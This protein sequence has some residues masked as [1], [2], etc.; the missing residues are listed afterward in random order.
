VKIY[1]GIAVASILG[2]AFLVYYN[3]QKTKRLNRIIGKQKTELEELGHVKDRIFS[4]VSHDM[5]TPV[6]TLISFIDIL[7]DDAIPQ[8]K[9]QLYAGELKNQLSHTSVLM[10]NLLNWASS[11]MEGFTPLIEP[12]AVKD[13]VDQTMALLQQQ[14]G[15]KNI[16]I[17]NHINE[18][19]RVRG[20]RNMFALITR[21][22]L[23][24]AIKFTPLNGSVQVNT[25][26]KDGMVNI[27]IADTG[28]GMPPEKMK[29][30]N[31]PEYL[32]A[33]DSK[34]GTQG[35]TGT[36]LG[37]MLCKTFVLLMKGSISAESREGGGSEFTISLPVA[38]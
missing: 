1:L 9:L 25:T 10:E 12:F 31:D 17:I 13:P 26:V 5:R 16:R 14:A 2:I 28:T 27:S 8:E 23:S 36:G 22:L 11:Q 4:V 24:N 29:S 6:N 3:Q 32:H 34:K 15:H 19:I 33:I 38:G 18:N 37:L 21:N 30:F 20:D 35:E 7:E